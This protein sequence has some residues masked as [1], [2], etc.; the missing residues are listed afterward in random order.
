MDQ[1]T[2][3]SIATAFGGRPGIDL[4][5]GLAAGGLVVHGLGG[6]IDGPWTGLWVLAGALVCALAVRSIRGREPT[7]KGTPGPPEA[8]S[9]LLRA[10]GEGQVE[11]VLSQMLQQACALP[12]VDR[13]V[14]FLR[15]R[16]DPTCS[17][18]VAARG[19]PGEVLG[20]RFQADRGALGAAL[21]SGR[22][23][24][25]EGFRALA[26]PIDYP[27]TADLRAT[28]AVP[29][30]CQ[31][32]TKGA[33]AV[34]SRER[35][36]CFGSRDL[37]VL[38]RLADLGGVALEQAEN[39][40]QLATMLRSNVEENR[41]QLAT[42]LR[43]NVEVL[44][45]AVEAR[46]H[47]T[48]EH[49]DEVVGLA[50]E[51]GRRQ[52]LSR[53]Q[54]VEL[55]F[56][57]RLHDLGKIGVPDAILHKPGPLD[58]SEWQ[59]MRTHPTVGAELLRQVPGLLMVA[60]IVQAAHERWDGRGYPAGLRGEDIPIASRIIFACDAYHAMTSHRCYRA[61]LSAEAAGRELRA[62]AGTQFDPH[63]VA[64]LLEEV[65][66]SDP[67]PDPRAAAGTLAGARA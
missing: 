60:E 32:Q 35:E 47:Q 54:L 15:D 9:D 50:L 22:P 38:S 66:Q 24:V 67:S 30:S 14:V 46:D 7:E 25:V 26:Q 23:Q 19:V 4:L 29:I 8:N 2:N 63:A 41:E 27:V 39:R 36:R 10:V 40:E 62:N 20:T 16:S 45:A 48:G 51:V 44:A 52:G 61:A 17:V 43:S 1:L 37:D 53:R 11:A 21:T 56:A 13:A 65:E 18:A 3:R 34:G 58:E 64:T 5:L 6:G 31:G 33:L 57:A 42:M 12:A 59:V 28:A 55:E 49:S